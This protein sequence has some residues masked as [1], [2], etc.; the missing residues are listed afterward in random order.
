MVHTANVER[1]AF[2]ADTIDVSL[3][4]GWNQLLVKVTNASGGWE[5][6]AKIRDANGDLLKGVRIKAE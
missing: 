6:W 3:R 5:A 1:P 4:E 2:N